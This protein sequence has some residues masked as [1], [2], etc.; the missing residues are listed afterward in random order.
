MREFTTSDFDLRVVEFDS[1]VYLDTS[2]DQE[3][4]VE[5]ARQ[6]HDNYEI[7]AKIK[8]HYIGTPEHTSDCS[9]CCYLKP[10][11]EKK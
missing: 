5:L 7:I 8:E 9:V 6:I 4:A 3:E 10:I 11:L 1:G 2:M